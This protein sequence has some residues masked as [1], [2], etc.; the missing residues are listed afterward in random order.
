MTNEPPCILSCNSNVV[1]LNDV[2]LTI[3]PA[4]SSSS[5]VQSSTA[6]NHH[7][8]INSSS[9]S[10]HNSSSHN[11]HHPSSS[12]RLNNSS[13][14]HRTAADVSPP[15]RPPRNTHEQA[16]LD[17][18]NTLW[19]QL[20]DMFQLKGTSHGIERVLFQIIVTPEYFEKYRVKYKA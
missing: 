15:R 11:H 5:Y 12:Q 18:K 3:L 9:S 13:S 10:N 7:Q 20:E 19:C 6:D 1:D 14:N 8:Q 4:S 2:E 17:G 16:D